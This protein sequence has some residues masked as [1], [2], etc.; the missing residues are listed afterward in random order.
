MSTHKGKVRPQVY[1]IYV[2]EI[3]ISP[4]VLD[5]H[6]SDKNGTNKNKI[7]KVVMSV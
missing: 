4:S 1:S 3:S 2:R 5:N 7:E 6:D